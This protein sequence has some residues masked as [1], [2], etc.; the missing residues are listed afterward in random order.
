MELKRPIPVVPVGLNYFKGH[1][2]RGRVFVD[3][4]DPIYPSESLLQEY[5]DPS[6]RRQAVA[7]FLK[8]ISKSLR[9]VTT[10]TQDFE[11]LKL[12]WALR[13][14]YLRPTTRLN[15]EEK[16]RMTRSFA[17]GYPKVRDKPEIQ[18]L[19]ARVKTYTSLLQ[20]YGSVSKSN[21]SL[22]LISICIFFADTTF[23]VST[24]PKLFFSFSLSVLLC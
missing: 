7:T 11:T 9:N 6:T 19:I 2:F 20:D 16:Q 4:E 1:M 14:L 18:E 17:E 10:E 3:I 22:V 13:R 24:C 15:Y 12:Y 5:M 21:L 23:L 8:Q